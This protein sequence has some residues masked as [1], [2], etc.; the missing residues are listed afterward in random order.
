MIRYNRIIY[1]LDSVLFDS[2]I[3]MERAENGMKNAH[4]KFAAGWIL[5]LLLALLLSPAQAAEGV[6]SGDLDSFF[7]WVYPAQN[8][9]DGAVLRDQTI[10]IS[11]IVGKG[12]AADGSAPVEELTACAVEFVSGDE[13]LRDAVRLTID[14]RNLVNPA[15]LAEST[16]VTANISIDNSRLSAPGS[17]SFT[18]TFRSA[19]YSVRK[20]ETLT[21]LPPEDLPSV[22]QLTDNPVFYRKPGDTFTT[23]D[24]ARLLVSADLIDFCRERNLPVPQYGANIDRIQQAGLECPESADLFCLTDYGV[25]DLTMH[26]FIA[27]AQWDIPFRVQSKPYYLRGASWIMPGETAKYTITDEDAAASRKFTFS[28]T[29]NEAEIDPA[30]GVLKVSQRA[31]IGKPLTVAITP[32]GD[33]PYTMTVR[34]VGGQL[35]VL[36]ETETETENGFLVPVPAGA[37]WNTT[38]SPERDN[39]WIYRTYGTGEN[40]S[41]LILE[42]RT[43]ST[44]N[45]FRED[46]LA[47]M[48]YYDSFSF[49]SNARNLR[50]EDVRIDGHTAR[51][52]TYTTQDKSGKLY[53]IGEVIYTRNNTTLTMTLYA[54]KDGAGESALSPVTMEDMKRIAAEIH[55]DEAQA[56]IRQADTALSAVPEDGIG[57]VSAGKRIQMTASF[58]NP[59]AVSGQNGNAGVLWEILDPSTGTA[60]E[61]A[62]VDRDGV[63]TVRENLEAETEVE[64]RAVSEVFGT[65]A[66]CRLTL[67][68]ASRRLSVVPADSF[69]Y[70]GTDLPVRLQAEIEPETVPL[71]G[72]VW[73]TSLPEISEVVPGEDGSAAVSFTDSPQELTV[74]VRDPGG[75]KAKSVVHIVNPVTGL[76]ISSRGNAKPGRSMTFRAVPEPKYNIDSRFEWS[77]NVG[78]EVAVIGKDGVLTVSKNAQPGT[79]ITVTCKALGAPEPLIAQKQVTVE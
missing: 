19:S 61:D 74:T 21:V 27:N 65:R 51:L 14:Q 2:I 62:S 20:E 75:R 43:D 7:G 46:D 58:A 12:T 78:E 11:S 59:E 1:R 22:K 3:P 26:Y 30:A 56:S 13:F 64:V 24:A 33:E 55:Y 8:L 57:I 45:V 79:V 38:V 49:N 66:S 17:A 44:G 39:G 60:S 5:V 48:R 4:W 25:F 53:R 32:E 72:L 42:A 35:S 29:G 70:V 77:L 36:P 47:A 37:G 28:V 41:A 31:E 6:L 16:V 73:S 69:Y 10:R 40:G 34:V 63:V 15:T 68:P 67:I 54:S 71:R 50:S 23:A 18:F 9:P 76:E 52:Y